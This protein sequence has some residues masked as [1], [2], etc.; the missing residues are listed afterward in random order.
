MF[1]RRGTTYVR[2]LLLM[3]AVEDVVQHIHWRPWLDGDAGQ[4]VALVDVADELARA[5][6]EGRRLGG[7]LGGSGVGSLMVEAVEVAAGGLELLDPLFGLGGWLCVLVG[8]FT[9]A[10]LAVEKREERGLRRRRGAGV[11]ERGP[12]EE[13]TS[14]IIMWQSKVPLP[15]LAS[16]VSTWPRI[17]VTTGAPK[18]MFGTKWPSLYRPLASPTPHKA[19]QGKAPKSSRD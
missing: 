14:A 6:L 7:G 19:R 5:R 13:L 11:E 3:G 10:L 17:L 12:G 15:N 2:P 16:G 18:V 8:S 4:H 1:G 9:I